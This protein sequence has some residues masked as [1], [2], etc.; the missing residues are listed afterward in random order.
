MDDR[1]FADDALVAQHR[2]FKRD[3]ARFQTTLPSDDD[4]AQ[5]DAFT[6][7]RVAPDD[8]AVNVRTIIHDSERTNHR[9]SMNDD[10]AL[11]AC[12]F[13]QINRTEQ[14]RVRR[15]LDVIL[16]ENSAANVPP[17]L[18]EIHLAFEQI[19]RGARVLGNVAD[20]TPIAA[21]DVTIQRRAF[22]H[23]QRK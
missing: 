22:F 15:D 11:D 2:A 9:R 7:V 20:I 16:D 18:A 21:G 3:G 10:T 6:D 23:Q 19:A 12:A 5:F 4:A 1:A 8:T 14:L 13:T 17:G